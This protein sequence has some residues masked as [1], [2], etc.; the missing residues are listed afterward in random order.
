MQFV[1]HPSSYANVRR[2]IN[3][4]E[5]VPNDAVKIE[6]M[7]NYFNYN[8]AQPET[9]ILLPFILKQRF[10]PGMRNMCWSK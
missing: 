7:I 1:V 10:V 2:M 6:E 4:G 9:N 8:Y 3:N 5:K